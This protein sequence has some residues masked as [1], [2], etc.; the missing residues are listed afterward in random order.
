MLFAPDSCIDESFNPRRNFIHTTVGWIVSALPR[1]N[2]T[3]KMRHHSE[4]TAIGRAETG[5]RIV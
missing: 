4:V 5:N 1:E 3:L 2:G